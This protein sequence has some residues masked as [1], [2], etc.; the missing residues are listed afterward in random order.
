MTMKKILA[1]GA[2][3]ALLLA[4]AT[5][6]FAADT[7]ITI[8]NNGSASVHNVT[9]NQTDAE[10]TTQ[11]V[12]GD[13]NNTLTHTTVSGDNS[14][15]DNVGGT[16]MLTS[17]NATSTATVTNEGSTN[18]STSPVSTPQTSDVLVDNNGSSAQ[19]TF[20]LTTSRSVTRNQSHNRART[21]G[22]THITRSGGSTTSRNTN[23]AVTQTSGASSSTT[24]VTNGGDTNT[25]N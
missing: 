11:S 19:V 15:D 8:T 3:A 14:A 6:A 25:A 17:G 18:M 21:T 1:A 20:G 24:T 13:V 7:T 5:P 2:S 22:V 16:V 4:M 9:V 12:A 10:N 23:G